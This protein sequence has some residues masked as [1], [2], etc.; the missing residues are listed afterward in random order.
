MSRASPAGAGTVDHGATANHGRPPRRL[1]RS[2]T[3][4]P[5][6]PPARPPVPLH[7]PVPRP[8]P[9][10][11]APPP[12]GP[13]LPGG[14]A[15]WLAGSRRRAADPDRRRSVVAG[16]GGGRPDDPHR[17]PPD[18]PSTRRSIWTF[19]SNSVGPIPAR[20]RVFRVVLGRGRSDRAGHPRR[21]GRL[22]RRR[23]LAC[24]RTGR[25]GR[26]CSPARPGRPTSAG[27]T[28]WP[29]L[30]G[31][32]A[33]AVVALIIALPGL[34]RDRA[35]DQRVPST[36]GSD[37]SSPGWS[38]C[39]PPC[40]ASSTDSGVSSW[41]PVC[42]RRLPSGW[43]TTSASCPSSGLRHPGSYVN[44]VFACG[45]VCA[46]T[47]IPIITSVSRDVMSQ[48]P[49]DVCE[50]AM[51]LGG[52]RWGMITDVIFPFSRSGI[53]S[54]GLLGLGPGL[55]ETM[56]VVLI[57]SPANKLT[58][59]LLG[60]QGLGS[61]AKEITEDFPNRDPTGPERPGPARTGPLPQHAGRERRLAGDRRSQPRGRPRSSGPPSGGPDADS[62][63]GTAGPHVADAGTSR[64][65]VD[66]PSAPAQVRP[67]Q[68]VEFIGS[69]V[70]RCA[71]VWIGFSIAGVSGPFG[72]GA[73]RG[74]RLFFADLR[75]GQL[76]G[77][78]RA[79]D[80]GPTGDRGGLDRWGDRHGPS[81][82]GH[83]LRGRQ[84]LARW[85]WPTSPT[86]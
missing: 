45:L 32:I 81:G 57:L 74:P 53:V 78:R 20:D 76:A 48:T 8:S 65:S 1:P 33:I 15:S 7:T 71:I 42:R 43:S 9:D 69:A 82:G 24:T 4:S 5:S 56:I 58:P 59:A 79:D 34:H 29:L 31:S 77:P 3:T 16:S 51:G 86:S 64:V 10:R 35:D 11:T 73:S 52:T 21:C 85:P 38:T 62:A 17:A 55:G 2:P 63:E 54:A 13:Q 66:R 41:S 36:R 19:R 84:G 40:R 47:I 12:V 27:S 83:R 37:R 68:L 18:G 60:P 39:W 49:R 25:R 80:E 6:G 44:S 70:A 46:V 30:V 26:S 28:C 22:P 14:P 50:A 75:R 23:R 72:I 67:E 61:I